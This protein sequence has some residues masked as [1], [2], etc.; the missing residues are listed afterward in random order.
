MNCVDDSVVVAT[1]DEVSLTA[2][3]GVL[4]EVFSFVNPPDVVAMSVVFAPSVKLDESYISHAPPDSPTSV[5]VDTALHVVILAP[6]SIRRVVDA[7]VTVPSLETCRR[8]R[9]G[10]VSATYVIAVS[11]FP[12][13]EELAVTSLPLS[14]RQ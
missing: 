4:N 14:V 9:T 13:D 5:H 8:R 1:V 11:G 3:F 2:L 12:L 6:Y 10:V 7:E